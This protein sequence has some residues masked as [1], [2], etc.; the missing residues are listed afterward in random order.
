MASTTAMAGSQARNPPALRSSKLV[1]LKLTT[2]PMPVH[3]PTAT[4]F[5]T[6]PVR[7][8]EITNSFQMSMNAK[9]AVTTTPGITMRRATRLKICHSLAPKAA[10]AS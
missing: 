8:L 4:V 7:M 3:T 5:A 9:R 1:C 2:S 10:A 6:G